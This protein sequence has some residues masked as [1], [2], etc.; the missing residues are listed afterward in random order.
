MGLTRVYTRFNPIHYVEVGVDK[1]EAV[2]MAKDRT[3]SADGEGF[4]RAF[5]DA[6]LDLGVQEDCTIVLYIAP[7]GRKGVIKV[8][9]K[10]YEEGKKGDTEVICTYSFEYPTAAISS[11]EASLYAGV[12][13]LDRLVADAHQYPGG[14]G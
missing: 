10:A 2:P 6:W 13:K 11:L 4:L 9:L 7:S 14:R 12:V 5:T 8:T 3:K 1:K